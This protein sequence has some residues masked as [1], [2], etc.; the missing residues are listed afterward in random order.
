MKSYYF[1]TVQRV[2]AVLISS[3]I[4]FGACKSSTQNPDDVSSLE[5]AQVSLAEAKQGL[6]RKVIYHAKDAAIN[7]VVTKVNEKL[8]DPAT[9]DAICDGLRKN[10]WI[11]DSLYK[12]CQPHL[13]TTQEFVKGFVEGGEKDLEETKNA[14]AGIASDVINEVSDPKNIGIHVIKVAADSPA[15]IAQAKNEL[16]TNNMQVK[17]KSFLAKVK[18]C[19]EQSRKNVTSDPKAAGNVAA[20]AALMVFEL[21]K[22]A[23][24]AREAKT[25]ELAEGTAVTGARLSAI[26]DAAGDSICKDLGIAPQVAIE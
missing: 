18:N 26:L 19:A 10:R 14:F 5:S 20:H 11:S 4:A 24:V 17:G 21:G 6:F 13:Q 2:A 8:A 12:R 25:L 1:C 3:S 15:L 9:A 7:Q 22:L 16:N 23:K